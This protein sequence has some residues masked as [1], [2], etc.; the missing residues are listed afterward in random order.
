MKVSILGWTP[1]R[2]ARNTLWAIT[3][4]TARMLIQTAYFILIA[5]LLGASGYGAFVGVAAMIAILS[6]FAGMGTGIVLLK[7]ASRNPQ[8]LPFYWGR[9][10]GVVAASGA[11]LVLVSLSIA[12]WLLPPSIPR[13]IVLILAISD[14][15]LMPAHLASTQ[16]FQARERLGVMT[17]LHMVLTVARLLAAV[18]MM[19]VVPT[20]TAQDLAWYYLAATLFAAVVSINYVIREYGA[21]RW[22]CQGLLSDLREGSYY[23]LGT[24]AHYII[25][26]VDKA[27]LVSLAS[28]G[29]A[30]IYTAAQRVSEAVLMPV[31]ALLA[32]ATPRLFQRGEKG[33]KASLTVVSRLLPLLLV[34]TIAAAVGLY[35]IAP[36]LPLL[37]GA[38][39]QLTEPV[40]RWLAVLPLVHMLH[41]VAA[42]ALTGAGHQRI[43]S[44]VVI[45]AAILNVLLNLWWIRES[46]YLGSAWALLTTFAFSSTCLWFASWWLSRR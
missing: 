42:D 41:S 23:S 28:S 6:A 44:I 45:S 43:R 38:Q 20:P 34:Y 24:F 10:L 14:L 5:R 7:E 4:Q 3:G 25:S 8:M 39:Y 37:F 21:P 19:T 11:V 32:A 1:G 9:S 36:L 29:A 31:L 46:S 33:I 30:G 26:N 22:Q 40:A 16:V 27:L 18:I 13:S 15:V 2:L 17:V 35:L 12:T